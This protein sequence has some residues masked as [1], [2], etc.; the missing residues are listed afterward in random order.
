MK[1]KASKAIL[2]VLEQL[3]EADRRDVLKAVALL[4]GID[5]VELGK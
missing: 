4:L 5:L 1:A 3:S 2:R